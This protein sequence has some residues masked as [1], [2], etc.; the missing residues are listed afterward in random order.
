MNNVLATAR[1]QTRLLITQ[2]CE[3]KNITSQPT[4][5][6]GLSGGPDSVF[7]FHV[8][9]GLQQEGFLT[10]IVAHLD[11]EWRACS[12]KDAQFCTTLC[13]AH[14]ITLVNAKASN[15]SMNINFN[16][17]Y[18]DMGRRMRRTLFQDVAQQFSADFIA[19]AHHRQDQHETF[20]MRLA[21]GATLTG[22][23]C[24]RPIDGMYLRPLLQTNK[25]DMV[26]YLQA[27]NLPFC[28]DPTNETDTYLRNRIRKYLIPELTTIDARFPQ[29]IDATIRHLQEEDAF[30]HTLTQEFFEKTYKKKQEST[31][32]K[33]GT[34]LGNLTMFK[35]LHPAMQNRVLIHWLIAEKVTF[36]PSAKFFAELLRFITQDAGGCHTINRWALVKKGTNMWITNIPSHK[37]P[38]T[39][40]L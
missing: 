3:Q 37:A 10:F 12:H 30:L 13:A 15:L 19:L 38:E 32:E 21:R 17:S 24:M 18:E 26:T 40:T 35:A 36:S 4:I 1:A 5:I 33:T 39:V 31:D 9:A 28:I 11:H 7:L 20:F 34:Y 27:N 8:L 29:K 22:L 25:Q 6:L 16:G 23:T 2:A 14:D